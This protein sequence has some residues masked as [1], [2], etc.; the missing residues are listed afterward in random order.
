MP[1]DIRGNVRPSN[2]STGGSSG[3]SG[4]PG[5]NSN[6]ILALLAVLFKKPKWLLAIVAIGAIWWFM[7]GG[8][9]GDGNS[10]NPV[11]VDPNSDN[12]VIV[13]PNSDPNVQYNDEDISRGAEL[14]QSVYDQA[15]V[16]EP[17][18]DNVK[19]PLPQKFSLEQYCP[20]RLSQ[21][22]QGSCVGWA[23]SYAARTIMHARE[24]GQ[25]PD[26]V[27]FSP[28]FLYNQI[29]LPN[30]Q[31]AYIFK[32]MEHL[33]QR[34]DVP[35]KDFAYDVRSCSKSP[36]RAHYNKASNYKIPGYTRL[37]KGGNNYKTDLLA[38]KQHIAHGAPVV[39]GMMVGG[40]FMSHMRGK[41]KWI[42]TKGD[43]TKRGFGGHAMCVVGYDDYKFGANMG[44]FQIMNSWGM[45]W[46]DKG[47]FWVSYDDF[48]RFTEEA[49][50]MY[51]MGDANEPK[52]NQLQASF[53]L[54]K[55]INGQRINVQHQSGKT[56]KTSSPVK[57]GEQFKIE[58]ENTL[59][60]YTY[61]VGLETDNSSYT[62]FPYT[63]K[64]SPYCGITGTRLFPK[65]YSY[66]ADNQGTID[67][68]AIV[69]SQKPIDYNVLVS[70]I[71]RSQGNFD[72]RIANAL[73]NILN[74]SARYS[75]NGGVSISADTQQGTACYAVLEVEKR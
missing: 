39:V 33:K 45:D 65:D 37:S 52:T 2:N 40:T 36:T 47:M 48:G 11:I 68:M 27:R 31:G 4:F 66:E 16:Y 71:N 29:A 28:S 49:Y 53:A 15:S 42:P 50:G 58:V 38:I 10:D 44:G 1:S 23:S 13:D 43:Y 60:C 12:T 7:S 32:A 8:L 35:L 21:G 14:D 67:Q 54:V 62:L 17:L 18:A 55:N 69:V 19:N 74:H 59:P 6:I 24:T 26:Q 64:H 41:D 70:N 72:Q 63:K 57:V 20:T 75:G 46:G 25:N 73:G 22:S 51:P 3:G 30:C 9:G 61:I 34:G 56:Y 5:G